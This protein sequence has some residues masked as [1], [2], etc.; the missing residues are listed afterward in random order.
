MTAPAAITT[1]TSQKRGLPRRPGG[2]RQGDEEHD[3][4][5]PR[6]PQ[7]RRGTLPIVP[8]AGDGVTFHAD[9]P[10]PDRR[11]MAEHAA[12]HVRFVSGNRLGG[13]T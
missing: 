6:E 8:A 3:G 5:R 4:P 10:N 1:P 7:R 11:S 9:L 13:R 12:G 2:P